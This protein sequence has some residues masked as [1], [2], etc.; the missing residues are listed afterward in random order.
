MTIASLHLNLIILNLNQPQHHYRYL[1][2]NTWI[3][4]IMKH[5]AFDQ[6]TYI[7]LSGGSD[8]IG[9]N[10]AAW[11]RGRG[12]GDMWSGYNMHSA[13]HRINYQPIQLCYTNE[14]CFS[15]IG[16]LL[17]YR[18]ALFSYPEQLLWLVTLKSYQYQLK[19]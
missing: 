9:G 13:M 4:S 6:Y 17:F 15:N 18:I 16:Y 12:E 10:R 19:I 8:N 1:I 3:M 11:E 7:G 2:N 5:Q 14:G